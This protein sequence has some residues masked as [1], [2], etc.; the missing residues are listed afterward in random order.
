[1][2]SWH[3]DVVCIYQNRC[4]LHSGKCRDFVFAFISKGLHKLEKLSSREKRTGT[5]RM[6]L[7]QWKETFSSPEVWIACTPHRTLGWAQVED[8]GFWMRIWT[9]GRQSLWLCERVRQ[10]GLGCTESH[11]PGQNW[12]HKVRDPGMCYLQLWKFYP[13]L[14]LLSAS[15]SA[16]FVP[17]NLSH[18][19]LETEPLIK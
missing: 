2:N 5:S 14:C 17:G 11:H 19:W 16:T 4:D 1:M 18:D 15:G 6:F 13:W 7:A 9:S 12:A 10:Q 8:R 3:Y